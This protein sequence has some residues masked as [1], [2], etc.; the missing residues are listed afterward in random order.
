MFARVLASKRHHV[1]F[2]LSRARHNFPFFC[3]TATSHE[4]MPDGIVTNSRWLLWS[5]ATERNNRALQSILWAK[6]A[7]A[8]V[9][10]TAVLFP[11]FLLWQ[12]WPL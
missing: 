3:T 10:T 5:S 11:K 1:R 7:F 8:L 4:C 2:L 12:S 9:C 6:C